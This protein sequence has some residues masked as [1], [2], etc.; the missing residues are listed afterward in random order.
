M[1]PHWGDS[2]LPKEHLAMPGHLWLSQLRGRWRATGT[3]EAKDVVK[4]PAKAR[5]ASHKELS[6]SK[7]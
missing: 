3:W 4:H 5:T 7:C 2:A 6:D 1:V